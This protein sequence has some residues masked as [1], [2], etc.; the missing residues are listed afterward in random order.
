MAQHARTPKR[1][2]TTNKAQVTTTRETIPILSLDE[3]REKATSKG[4]NANRS[5]SQAWDESEA[6]GIPSSARRDGL[7]SDYDRKD[8]LYKAYLNNVWISSSSEVIAKRITS[9]G[10]A[11]EEKEQGKGIESEQAA[12]SDL[13]LYV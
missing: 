10:F 7:L 4:S 1:Q 2:R 13:L 6:L 9:G 5:L 11:I 3:V 12:L 8:T